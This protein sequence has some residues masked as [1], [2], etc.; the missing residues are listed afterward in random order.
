MRFCIG[1][2]YQFGLSICIRREIRGQAG[3]LQKEKRSATGAKSSR[4]CPLLTLTD[5]P[6]KNSPVQRLAR[7]P[8]WLVR[9]GM[10]AGAEGF[11]DLFGSQFAGEK[12]R[13]QSEVMTA[14]AIAGVRGT[15]FVCAYHEGNARP[16]FS[17]CF[18]FTDRATTT[19]TVVVSNNPP[20][21]GTEVKVGP[22]QM[23]TVACLAAPLAAFTGT[24]GVLTGT[25]ATGAGQ[26][27]LFC[28]AAIVGIGAGAA[29]AIGGTTAAVIE[30]TGGRGG[31]SSPSH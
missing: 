12:G 24:L 29:A 9:S 26:A 7:G 30:S 28:S 27:V 3:R 14:N 25:V 23:T 19:G 5:A 11:G 15:D 17:N 13:G 8:C 16:G 20:R 1:C 6:V 22:G 31:T 18:Q 4:F 2:T 21:P 10:E